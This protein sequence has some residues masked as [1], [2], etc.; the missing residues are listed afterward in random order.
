MKKTFKIKELDC[1]NCANR[2]EK[3]ISKIDG[4]KS[5]SVSFVLQKLTI[6]FDEDKLESI[7]LQAQTVCRRI[8]RD[9]QIVID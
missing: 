1:A 5:V 6:E 2:M 4:V 8:K 3:A 9:C 7:L